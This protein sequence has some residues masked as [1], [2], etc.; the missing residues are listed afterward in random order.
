MPMTEGPVGEPLANWPFFFRYWP[1]AINPGG[2][3]AAPPIWDGNLRLPPSF[4]RTVPRNQFEGARSPASQPAN[5]IPDHRLS[6]VHRHQL[7]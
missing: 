5:R 3:G 1:H 4:F 7:S 6:C 2:L